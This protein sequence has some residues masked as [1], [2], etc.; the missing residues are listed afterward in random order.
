MT[1]TELKAHAFAELVRKL[2]THVIQDLIAKDYDHALSEALV[3]SR[4][5]IAHKREFAGELIVSA[6]PKDY[7]LS[8]LSVDLQAEHPEHDMKGKPE[9]E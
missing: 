3:L 1:D 9:R 6:S 4:E 8:A 2:S 7:D 5:A